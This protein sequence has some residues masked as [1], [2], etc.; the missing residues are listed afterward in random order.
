VHLYE[1]QLSYGVHE[2]H[3]IYYATSRTT[4]NAGI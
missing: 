3:H 4:F 1:K 2:I